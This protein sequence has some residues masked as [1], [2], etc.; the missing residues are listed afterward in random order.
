MLST[1]TSL[2][3]VSDKDDSRKFAV[4]ISGARTAGGTTTAEILGPMG[5]ILAAGRHFHGEES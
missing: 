5:N 2:P 3:A 1:P 4:A